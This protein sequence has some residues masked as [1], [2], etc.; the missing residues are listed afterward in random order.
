MKSHK[1]GSKTTH[2]FKALRKSLFKISKSCKIFTNIFSSR[3]KYLTL[4]V[5]KK[6]G[7]IYFKESSQ[8]LRGYRNNKLFLIFHYVV[9]QRV[10]K[11]FKSLITCIVMDQTIVVLNRWPPQLRG[12]TQEEAYRR[13]VIRPTTSNHDHDKHLSRRIWQEEPIGEALLITK[14]SIYSSWHFWDG[15]ISFSPLL[16]TWGLLLHFK[17]LFQSF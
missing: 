12:K 6:N 15:I 4:I 10:C 14:M 3:A 16:N 2:D 13:R 17:R 5:L 7:S 1:K 8:T 11:S 9:A